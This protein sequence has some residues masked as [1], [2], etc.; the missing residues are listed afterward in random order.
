MSTTKTQDGERTKRGGPADAGL[1]ELERQLAEARE[2][3]ARFRKSVSGYSLEE[4]PAILE[5]VRPLD[6]RVDE[7]ECQ[8]A[9]APAQGLAG[10]GVNPPRHTPPSAENHEISGKP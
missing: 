6:D 10:V 7:L 3:S 1:L 9:K 8:I 5:K 4:E 2:T